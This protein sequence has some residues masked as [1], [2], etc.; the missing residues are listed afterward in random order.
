M[1]LHS[2]RRLAEEIN[3][4]SFSK[5]FLKLNFWFPSYNILT[6]TRKAIIYLINEKNLSFFSTI[7]GNFC[8]RS[9]I[10]NVILKF[11]INQ[12]FFSIQWI[13]FRSFSKK[14]PVAVT[15]HFCRYDEV[16]SSVDTIDIFR[17]FNR[18]FLSVY[19]QSELQCCFE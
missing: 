1:K 11:K 10:Q 5:E 14:V 19:P 7:F 4:Y 18:K 16:N 15:E 9:N 8:R 13:L 17:C 6:N 12:I 3:K 2:K